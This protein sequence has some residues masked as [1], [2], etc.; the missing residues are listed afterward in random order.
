MLFDWAESHKTMVVLN[1]GNSSDLKQRYEMFISICKGLEYPYGIF[2]EDVE[3]LQGAITCVGVIVPEKI[4]KYNEF[5][6]ER[7]SLEVGP[8][9]MFSLNPI[10]LNT[11]EKELATLIA[12]AP[13]AR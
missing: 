5:E 1:G 8:L 7:R 2:R 13:L 3:S 11:A 10:T 9:G 4:Y 12:S 6:Q